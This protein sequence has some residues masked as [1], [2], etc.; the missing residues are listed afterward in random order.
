MYPFFVN[1]SSLAMLIL[2][3]FFLLQLTLLLLIQ[4]PE[5]Y[6]QWKNDLINFK[7]AMYNEPDLIAEAGRSNNNS[8]D[9]T[10]MKSNVTV[11]D[12]NETYDSDFETIKRIAFK[13][14]KQLFYHTIELLKENNYIIFIT[15]IVILLYIINR[16]KKGRLVTATMSMLRI[17]RTPKKTVTN[18]SK[19]TVNL[20][21]F[22]PKQIQFD[23]WITPFEWYLEDI[24]KERW[25]NTLLLNLSPH[26][27]IKYGSCNTYQELRDCLAKHDLNAQVQKQEKTSI[28]DCI[29]TFMKIRRY[30][31]ERLSEYVSRLQRY[32]QR[33]GIDRPEVICEVFLKGLKSRRM[34]AYI[35]QAYSIQLVNSA[36]SKGKS[37]DNLDALIEYADSFEKS[38]Q[39]FQSSSSSNSSR[40]R[41]REK[42]RSKT[43]KSKS[44]SAKSSNKS[45]S[46]SSDHSDSTSTTRTR[47]TYL[48]KESINLVEQFVQQVQNGGYSQNTNYSP[49]GHRRNNSWNGPY[50]PKHNSYQYSGPKDNRYQNRSNKN[51]FQRNR[52]DRN[53]QPNEF[54]NEIKQSD[55]N[56]PKVD[57]KINSNLQDKSV[58]VCS[59][60]VNESNAKLYG[61]ALIDHTGIH[62]LCDTGADFSIL[63]EQGF[64]RIRRLNKAACLTKYT[65]PQVNS[66]TGNMEILGVYEAKEVTINSSFSLY[67]QKFRVAK[68]ASRNECLIGRDLIVQIPSLNLHL[69]GFKNYLESSKKELIFNLDQFLETSGHL[70]AMV[71]LVESDEELRM[72]IEQELSTVGASNFNEIIPTDLL[73]HEIKLIDPNQPPIRHKVRPIP[74]SVREKL[75]VLIKSQVE[76]GILR[77]SNSPWLFPIN[78]VGKPGGDIRLTIDYR[79]LN[80][81]TQKDAHPLPI[82]DNLLVQL[83]NSYYKTKI[84]CFSGFYQVKM[85]INSIQF[86][87]FGCEFGLFEYTVMPMGLSNSPATFQRLMNLI[88][89][90]LID[91]GVMVI[92]IDDFLIFS[93]T[94]DE[95]LAN[96]KEVVSLLQKYKLKIKLSKCEA[97]ATE[98]KFLGHVVSFNNIRPD[99]EKITVIKNYERPT[100]LLELQSFIGLCSFYRKFIEK[101]A[102]IAK[103]IHA[104]METKQLDLDNS[105][106][107]KNGSLKT[108]RI[109]L[110]WTD[111]ATKAFETLKALLI[112]DNIL[113]MPDFNMM[114]YLST[115]ASNYAIGAVLQQGENTKL[116]RPIAYFSKQLNKAQINYAT[117]EKEL[118]A[119]VTGVEHFH[120]YL[121]GV[122]FT[123][124]TDHQPLSWL[125]KKRDQIASRL[126]RWVIRL[127]VY[128]FEIIYKTG[129]ANGNADALSRMIYSSEVE[130]DEEEIIICLVE[131]EDLVNDPATEYIENRIS[132]L[133]ELQ[134]AD[135]N[136]LWIKSLLME[137]GA[138]K[139]SIKS[140]PNATCELMFRQY[141]YL[142]V[143]NGVLYRQGANENKQ[144]LLPKS[145]TSKIIELV[146]G[147]SMGGHL[148]TKKCLG[149]ITQR[150]FYPNLKDEVIKFIKCCDACQRNKITQPVR[151]AELKPLT[152]SYPNQI[153]TIDL[154]GPMPITSKKNVFILVMVDA[155]TKFV[156][157]I[158]LPD[159]KSQTV[160]EAIIKNWI[161]IFGV[162]EF[163]LSDRGTNLQSMLMELI[164]EKFDIKPLRTSSY[165]PETD[166]ESERFIQT[167]KAM[168]KSFVNSKHNDWDDYLDELSFAYNTS[169][170][171]S[172]K[173]S[174]FEVTFGRMPRIPIDLIFDNHLNDI[175]SICSDENLDVS[176]DERILT[177]LHDKS[178]D[179]IVLDDQEEIL[180]PKLNK[181]VKKYC[182]TVVPRLN[183]VYE[184]V[185]KNKTH[186]MDLAKVKHD[187]K[188]KKFSYNVGDLVLTDHVKL[189]TGQSSGLAHKYHGPFEI[190]GVHNNKCNYIIKKR[191][192]N[193]KLGKKSFIIHKNRLKIY[194]GHYND[195][196][197]EKLKVVEEKDSVEKRKRKYTKNPNCQ[198]WQNEDVPP[199]TV[200]EVNADSTNSSMEWDFTDLVKPMEDSV[201]ASDSFGDIFE[202]VNDLQ[203]NDGA[204][205]IQ[206][207]IASSQSVQNNSYQSENKSD[208]TNDLSYRNYYTR[209]TN[210][211]YRKTKPST[212]N[213]PE[214]PVRRGE[215]NRRKPDVYQ[216]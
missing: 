136:I 192:D 81:I 89:K 130:D 131:Y 16:M 25:R 70:D 14:S 170:H 216:A 208:G 178:D 125:L 86:T 171:N 194:F 6:G 52:Q 167:M 159:N 205:S 201:V 199:I 103:P 50:N 43:R 67:N 96:V 27:A 31:G 38:H 95:H 23:N 145:I 152:S 107:K 46:K 94:R 133:V 33:A 64:D 32:A 77:P 4:R 84:D 165:H 106:K 162:P 20:D 137:H 142:F 187:R 48:S 108:N 73:T 168:L 8:S 210:K 183:T 5:L 149:K 124:F 182:D 115:D 153:V 157:A 118:L 65:G 206:V 155:F 120:H 40:S 2:P 11:N 74:F 151:R 99:P 188:I 161:C 129:K 41:S 200:T 122:K 57:P 53:V 193:G 47:K 29:E 19:V 113:I 85:N 58:Q 28:V 141:E 60:S 17:W 111:E 202:N 87:A 34:R 196:L 190:I 104:I 179:F 144:F 36:G 209:K 112:S 203:A 66:A 7:R 173:F 100:N 49:R 140:F 148:G 174:P 139:P 189:K 197:E 71:L 90:D 88:F 54:T 62:Y 135:E 101:F 146:H 147:T 9:F 207:E 91:R 160:A 26:L 117:C 97:L 37:I 123:I 30:H 69:Q 114:F 109:I 211:K 138:S 24:P 83:S 181:T 180:S 1:R 195:H 10:E 15:V 22:D 110:N 35:Q 39:Q 198:R 172:T 51:N 128:D 186:T 158:P 75:R 166:G 18:S 169:V 45:Y 214:Q 156:R 56:S 44:S 78:V 164:F 59:V 191:L 215:R 79:T 61:M 132:D 55:S 92:F 63:S 154:A 80:D 185:F 175:E 126:A 212:A 184:M 72:L 102:E 68:L 121:Y 119:I 150:F 76:A 163:V 127:R 177:V 176:D 213:T 12:L 143:L 82:I 204:K 3:L 42:K 105:Y 98:M 134:S 93:K 116:L 21:K 13:H